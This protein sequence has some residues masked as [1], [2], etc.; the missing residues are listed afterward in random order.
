[1]LLLN[2]DKYQAFV[3]LMN[4]TLSY[5]IIPFYRFEE[6]QIRKRLQIF[7]QIFLHN[8]PELCDYFES[9]D[10]LPE[11]YLIE[12]NMTIFSK[13][14]NI[15]IA[16]RIWDIYMIEG[17]GAIYQASIG[18]NFNFKKVI[19][20]HFEKRFYEMDFEYIMKTLKSTNDINFDE[21]QLVQMMK[22]VKFPE[23]VTTEIQ[24]LN[25]EY[26]PLY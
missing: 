16:A 20:S 21:D 2:M 24:K 14:L 5:N 17:I 1:M 13:S 12:W 25:D 7:K 3:A 10:I 8:L 26:I 19:L 11:H 23:W 22:G 4:I 9:L 6:N 15:D 18:K